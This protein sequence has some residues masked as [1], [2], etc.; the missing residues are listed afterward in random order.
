MTRL[1]RL[2]E[3]SWLSPSL[4][5]FTFTSLLHHYDGTVSDSQMN[6]EHPIKISLDGI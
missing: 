3:L 5:T 4:Y 6:F 2:S 1:N